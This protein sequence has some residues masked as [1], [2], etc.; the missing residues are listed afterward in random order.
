[1]KMN[2][3]VARIVE[4]MFQDV[5]MNEETSAIRDEVMNNCQERYNDLI[6]SGVQE[7]DAIAA[8]IESLKGMD[9]VLAPYKKKV[10]HVSDEEA[11]EEGGERN[12]AFT[13]SEIHQISGCLVNEDVTLEA[14]DD[15]DYHVIWNVDDNP[16]VRAYVDHGTLKIERGVEETNNAAADDVKENFNV[17]MSDFIRTERGKL[18]INMDSIDRAM[19]SLGN[20]LKKLRV[21]SKGG[22]SISIGD[23]GVTIQVPENAIPHTK[24]LTTSGDISVQNVALTELSVTSTSGDVSIDLDEEQNL[25]QIDIR[26]TSGDIEVSAFTETMMISSTSGDVEVE[27][28]MTSL[29]ANTIS[30]D[31]D[32]RADVVNMTFKAVSGDVDL[33]FE[34]NGISDVR[35]STISGDIDIDLPDGIGVIAIQTQSRSGD[36]TTRHHT[37]GFGPTVTGSVTSM[38]GDITIS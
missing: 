5:E 22:M 38:S 27:G 24:L 30:G 1:M 21:F 17:D 25:E 16:L 9:D 36:V 34:S 4:I 13:C 19:K 18:E 28:H 37:T 29:T 8:V 10:P 33:E 14:S 2:D 3:T 31:I 11:A 7:D 26:T 32:V 23:T 20:S 15:D 6:T 12:L 35:G